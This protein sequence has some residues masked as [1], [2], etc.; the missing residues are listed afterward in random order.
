M[1]LQE[2]GQVGVQYECYQPF[3]ASFVRLLHYQ[4]FCFSSKLLLFY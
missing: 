3:L 2:P 4:I 1:Q